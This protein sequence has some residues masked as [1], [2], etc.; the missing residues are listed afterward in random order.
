MVNETKR[1]KRVAQKIAV[2]VGCYKGQKR[3]FVYGL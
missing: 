2:E 3:K 1:D